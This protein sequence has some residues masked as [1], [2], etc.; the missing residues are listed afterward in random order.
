MIITL[1]AVALV[2]IGIIGVII[3]CKPDFILY[4]SKNNSQYIKP[5]AVFTDGYTYHKDSIGTD[6]AKRSTNGSPLA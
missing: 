4:P 3:D 6:M 5:I 2:V 1:I